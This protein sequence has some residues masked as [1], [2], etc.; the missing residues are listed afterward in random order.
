MIVRVLR[1]YVKGIEDK[2]RRV[3]EEF[4]EIWRGKKVGSERV[5]EG[6]TVVREK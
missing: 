6:N 3:K 1:K 4:G 5:E 2:R